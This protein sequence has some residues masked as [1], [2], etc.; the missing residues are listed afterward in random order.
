MLINL[1]ILECILIFLFVRYSFVY[2]IFVDIQA[3]S[4]QWNWFTTCDCHIR[5]LLL[6]EQEESY[7]DFRYWKRVILIYD[8]GIL[9][10]I[11]DSERVILIYD[12]GWELFWFIIQVES[13][14][15]LWYRMSYFDLLYWKR[16]IL[17]YWERVIMIYD[18]IYLVI[19]WLV[20]SLTWILKIFF[21]YTFFFLIKI[22]CVWR[23]EVKFYIN[24]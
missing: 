13:Y 7:F 22:S 5:F 15:D 17:I 24:F 11:Y 4:G 12:S 16:I 20:V 14:F 3:D 6:K 19:F 9:I 18:I 8:T 10:L 1:T 23:F 21:V 2:P